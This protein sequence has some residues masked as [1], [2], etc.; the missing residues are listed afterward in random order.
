MLAEYR[1][2][3]MYRGEILIVCTASGRRGVDGERDGLLS[4]EADRDGVERAAWGERR[5]ET[6]DRVV[7]EMWDRGVRKDSSSDPVA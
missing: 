4:R 6:L 3:E 5:C 7:G 1:D 2:C